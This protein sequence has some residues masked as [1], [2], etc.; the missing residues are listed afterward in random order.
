M[1][2]PLNDNIE[3]E[4]AWIVASMTSGDPVKRDLPTAPPETH[5]F[6]ILLPSGD[7][8]AL[9]VTSSVVGEV[10]AFWRELRKRP[11]DTQGL[12]RDWSVNVVNPQLD[13]PV[14]NVK[15]LQR[16]LVAQLK[17]L[18]DYVADDT[19]E[20]MMEM[21]EHA[22]IPVRS[23]LENLKR[24]GVNSAN[25]LR[26]V[27]R[28]TAQVAVGTGGPRRVVPL[29]AMI[30]KST[31]DNE[32]KISKIEASER[33]LFIWITA[34]DLG[35]SLR[36]AVESLPSEKPTIGGPFDLIWVALWSPR[37]N[38]EIQAQ[39]LWSVSAETGWTDHR[40]PMVRSYARQLR[41]G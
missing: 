31:A 40:L 5:D 16:W 36:L 1:I 34:S 37:Y 19:I 10:A 21:R 26:R 33:H 4:A 41:D 13:R 15:E 20:V 6:D 32:R 29:I 22:A 9:E 30:E 11:F 38:S 18:E 27:S 23:A 12:A 2:P 3:L 24:L 14:P 28:I 7:M 17:V 8:I 39:R 35:N 25:P